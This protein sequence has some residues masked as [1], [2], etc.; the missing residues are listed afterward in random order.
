M[1]LFQRY[2]IF[3]VLNITYQV[4]LHILLLAL[5]CYSY[6][7]LCRCT[8][9][10]VLISTQDA[11]CESYQPSH[12]YRSYLRLRLVVSMQS[13]R[14]YQDSHLKFF[15]VQQTLVPM[16]IQTSLNDNAVTFRSNTLPLYR[17]VLNCLLACL[18]FT[19][20]RSTKNSLPRYQIRTRTFLF[21]DLDLS[22]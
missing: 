12:L 5:V 9:I 8:D 19:I 6:Q 7:F 13:S 16:E 22:L 1:S 11:Y 20:L 21:L 14:I 2:Y 10:S 4:I 18:I 3:S 17:H 15:L